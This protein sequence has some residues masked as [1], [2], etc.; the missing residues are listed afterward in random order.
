[1][2][3]ALRKPEDRSGLVALIVWLLPG[4]RLKTRLLNALGNDIHPDVTIG[5]NIVVACGPFRVSERARVGALNT[6]RNMA[7]VRIG[8]GCFLGNLNSV[9][10]HP[11]FQPDH[12]WAGRLILDPESGVTSR[13]YLDCSGEIRIHRM[14][15]IG[16]VQSIL[17]SHE[18]DLRRNEPSIGRISIG[19][20]G[21]TATRALVLKDAHVP[22]RSVLA[23]GGVLMRGDTEGKEGVYAGNPARFVKELRDAKWMSR[24]EL[25]TPVRR[26]AA[27]RVDSTAEVTD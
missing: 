17:Q 25:D 23:A 5:P 16:G 7:E 21:L 18:I 9:T 22:P 14:A 19:E 20:Y 10:A 3:L 2:A 6:F 4:S 1:M 15:A 12:P 13:H 27:A 8:A 24:S 26:A 11:D